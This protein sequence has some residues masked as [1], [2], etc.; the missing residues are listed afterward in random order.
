MGSFQACTTLG[1]LLHQAWAGKVLLFLTAALVLLFL[2][3]PSVGSC[4]C[5]LPLASVQRE[6]GKKRRGG[7]LTSYPIMARSIAFFCEFERA[8][9]LAEG[10]S[11]FVEVAQPVY[12]VL[13]YLVEQVSEFYGKQGIVRGEVHEESPPLLDHVE[14]VEVSFCCYSFSF[15]Q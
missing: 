4:R 6:F 3:P 15:R 13:E 5:L 10:L 11:V 7:A 8:S 2:P 14:P 9:G 1:V 12:K